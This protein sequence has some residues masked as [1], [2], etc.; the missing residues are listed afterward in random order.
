[1]LG[2][3]LLEGLVEVDDLIR[4]ED[5]LDVLLVKCFTDV[6][7]VTWLEECLLADLLED[8]L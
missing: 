1:M 5:F 2:L 7:D 8:L 3:L 4:L 6:E